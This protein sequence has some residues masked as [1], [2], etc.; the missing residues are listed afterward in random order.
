VPVLVLVDDV[1]LVLVDAPP[2]PVLV[3]VEDVLL[4]EGGVPPVPVLVD[5][6]SPAFV[7]TPSPPLGGPPSEQPSA[8]IAATPSHA[9][10]DRA[11]RHLGG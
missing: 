10:R 3:L 7:V 11:I 6:G 1:L 9:I 8:A 2:I 4:V 5:G